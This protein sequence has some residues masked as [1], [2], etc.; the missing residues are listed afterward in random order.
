MFEYILKYKFKALLL[1]DC[2]TGRP[3]IGLQ[4]DYKSISAPGR[5][6]VQTSQPRLPDKACTDTHQSERGPFDLRSWG[7]ILFSNQFSMDTI[8]F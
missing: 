3:A 7:F 6:C 4:S 8:S 1:F 5:R 2:N